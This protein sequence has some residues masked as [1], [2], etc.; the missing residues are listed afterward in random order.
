MIFHS[1]VPNFLWVVGFTT[2]TFLIN[3]LPSSS[4]NFN[5]LYFRLYGVHPNYSILRVFGTRCYPYTWDTK[6]NK[7]DPKTIITCVFLGNN[8]KHKGYRCFD[9]KTHRMFVSRHVMFNENMFPYK[10]KESLW[11]S[12]VCIT[13]FLDSPLPTSMS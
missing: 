1:E 9:P 4:I 2:T 12:N 6:K 3:R 8:D 13:D 10:I 7:F 11:P 5:S